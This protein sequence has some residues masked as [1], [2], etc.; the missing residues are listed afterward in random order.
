MSLSV[1]RR[2]RLAAPSC[3]RLHRLHVARPA[4]VRG[5]L[6]GLTAPPRSVYGV[7]PDFFRFWYLRPMPR[8]CVAVLAVVWPI[9]RY[10]LCVGAAVCLLGKS[11]TF[12]WRILHCPD[13]GCCRMSPSDRYQCFGGMS[14]IKN[15]LTGTAVCFHSTVY[16]CH[17]SISENHCGGYCLLVT[18]RRID[19]RCGGLNVVSAAHWLLLLSSLTVYHR[20]APIAIGKVYEMHN[21]IL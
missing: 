11:L 17:W 19:R 2:V 8:S 3:H 6:C 7:R 21:S 1:Q 20:K 14:S 9:L 12:G 5:S 15:L 4:V 10:V 13:C 18:V 16:L